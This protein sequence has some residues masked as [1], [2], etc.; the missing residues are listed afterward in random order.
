VIRGSNTYGFTAASVVIT[1]NEPPP[2]ITYTGSTYALPLGVPVSLFPINT[3]GQV[4]TW[5][6]TPTL[7]TGLSFS[8]S[9]GAITGT[10]TVVSG[11]QT[12]TITATN[13][14]GTSTPALALSCVQAV[15][16][17]AYPSGSYSLYL[18]QAISA[19]VP[20]NSGGPATS[21]SINPPLSAGLTFDTT[22]GRIT[23]TPTAAAPSQTYTIT[24]ANA[25]GNGTTSLVI[26]VS[27]QPP[28]ITVQPNGKILA[29]GQVPTFSV[30]ASGAG[31]LTYQWYLGGSP[32]TGATFST[33]TAPDFEAENDGAVY[34]VLVSDGFGGSTTSSPA[35][36]ALFLDLGTWLTAHPAIAAA[37]KWQIQSGDPF[38]YYIAPSDAQKVAWANWSQTQQA[39]LD[40]AYRSHVD[41]FNAGAPQVTMVPGGTATTL[42][43]QPTNLYSQIGLD[44]NATTVQVSEAD[45]WRLYT[46]HMAFSLMLELSRQVPW[47]VTAYSQDALRWLFDSSTMAWKQPDGHYGMGTYAGANQPALRNN[48]R[49]RTQFADPRWIFPWL[50]QAGILGASRRSTIGGFLD[51]MRGNLYHAVGGADTFASDFAIWQYRG[52]SPVS[53]IV[54]GTVDSRY[55]E[56]GTQHFTEGCHGSTGFLNAA[57]RVVNI[58]VQPIWMCGHELVYFMSEDLYMD[59]ADDPYNAVVRASSSP[60]LLLLIDSATWRSR[61]GA[62]ETLNN[63]DYSSP[64]GQWI[65]YTAVH[66]P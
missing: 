11:V 12:Y 64:V 57:L 6:I 32:I 10:P 58:P 19:L 56:L 3:G 59:H 9:T 63:W 55:P 20:V 60:S 24:A 62:D 48:N 30:T 2:V 4:T 61:F 44:A 37:I 51:Y 27:V 21:W 5:S 66:F 15:P 26:G 28:L 13:S 25:G 8:A 17:I 47:S 45:M 22:N 54:L 29:P 41:W 14:G 52:Y 43:D 16:H 53:K 34:T 65:G 50:Q 31:T 38:N 35:R 1:V 39:D 23:G 18:N 7:P 42:S 40:A 36:L 49:P 46:G 33:Y